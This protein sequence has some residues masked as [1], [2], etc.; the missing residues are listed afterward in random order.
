MINTK[1][2]NTVSWVFLIIFVIFVIWYIFGNSPLEFSL[3]V[4][5]AVLILTKLWTMSED[6]SHWKGDYSQFKENVKESFQRIK[7]HNDKVELELKDI[8]KILAKK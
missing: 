1:I 3:L 4:P 7:E 6:F 2:L 5:L 8:K